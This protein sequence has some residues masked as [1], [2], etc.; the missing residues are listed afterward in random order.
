MSQIGI[1]GWFSQENRDT[2]DKLIQIHDI[3]S[4]TEIG[5]F[6]GLSAVWFAQ[7][8]QSVTC[9]DSWFEPANAES[10]NNLL[11]TMRRWGIPRDFF[12]MFAENIMR[13]GQ[14]HKILPLRGT[15]E[16]MAEQ[17]PVA[18]LVYIDGDH[19]YAGC[20][21]DIELYKPLARKIICGD[22]YS[23]REGF[24]VIEAVHDMLPNH[25][26]C[27]PFWWAGL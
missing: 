26:H 21:R 5:S 1:A 17:V 4:V 3:K 14:W 2:L 10:Q 22:D 19:S 9:V 12:H 13:S 15:S 24:G 25:E 16:A 6:M 20:R 11:I 8:V 27:G 18:D 23:A 7:R